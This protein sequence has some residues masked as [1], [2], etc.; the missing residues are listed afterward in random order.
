MRKVEI[1][2]SA[3]RARIQRG[4]RCSSNA[5]TYRS[6][7]SG[8]L[9][10][11]RCAHCVHAHACAEAGHGTAA[12]S[13][14]RWKRRNVTAHPC[15]S[16]CERLEP[17]QLRVCRDACCR[18]L[19]RILARLRGSH[20]FTRCLAIDARICCIWGQYRSAALCPVHLSGPSSHHAIYV[21]LWP[22]Q[23]ER[24]ALAGR[25]GFPSQAAPRSCANI[26][27]TNGYICVTTGG[28]WLTN[29]QQHRQARTSGICLLQA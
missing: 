2:D 10:K 11:G 9:A 3:R 17:E 24:A 23:A 21:S 12:L 27:N 8:R 14:Q 5:A 15:M 18:A 29:V 20:I 19:A 1:Q 16:I 28:R 22:L 25:A 7:C 26:C 13:E 6:S 4:A